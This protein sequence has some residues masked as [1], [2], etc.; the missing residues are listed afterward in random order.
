MS[1]RQ[2]YE[3]EIGL[4]RFRYS[5]DNRSGYLLCVFRNYLTSLSLNVLKKTFKKF[6]SLISNQTSQQSIELYTPMS[7]GS[8]SELH[9]FLQIKCVVRQTA[10]ALTCNLCFISH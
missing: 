10:L 3:D 4:S 7:Y 1:H 2:Q 5:S 8:N 9:V 6:L